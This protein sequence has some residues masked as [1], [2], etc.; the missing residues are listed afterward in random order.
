MD[1]FY[2][3]FNGVCKLHYVFLHGHLKV[4]SAVQ[5]QDFTVIEDYVTGLKCLLYMESCKDFDNW[6]GQ[7]AP[8]V[9]HQKGKPVPRVIDQ[10]GKV[11]G[12]IISY[13]Y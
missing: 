1:Y 4:C 5:N 12:K 6:D 9:K 13:F 7:S 2:F 8:T 10:I 11:S 3:V